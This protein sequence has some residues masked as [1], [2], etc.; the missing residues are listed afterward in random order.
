MRRGPRGAE[1]RDLSVDE[2]EPEGLER[3]EAR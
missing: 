1:V 2:E 3:F